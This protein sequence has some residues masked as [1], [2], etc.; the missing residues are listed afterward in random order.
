[1][2]VNNRFRNRGLNLIDNNMLHQG[3]QNFKA[4]NSRQIDT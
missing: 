1:M 3:A 2:A 4:K